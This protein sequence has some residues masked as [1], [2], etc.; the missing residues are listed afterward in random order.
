MINKDAEKET[1]EALENKR[2]GTE[3]EQM[4]NLPEESERGA[5]KKKKEKET[6][7]GAKSQTSKATASKPPAG[8]SLGSSASSSGTSNKNK[9]TLSNSQNSASTSSSPA[10]AALAAFRQNL[11]LSERQQMKLALQSSKL[12]HHGV[13]MQQ[14]AV[15]LTTG[16]TE[17][18]GIKRQQPKGRSA[19]SNRGG[20]GG[21]GGGP[22]G[23]RAGVPSGQGRG[24]GEDKKIEKGSQREKKKGPPGAR[25]DAPVV[26]S[27]SSGAGPKG[28]KEKGK[29]KEAARGKGGKSKGEDANSRGACGSRDASRGPKGGPGKEDETEEPKEKE[30]TI[31]ELDLVLDLKTRGK[32]N[33]HISRLAWNRFRVAER[34]EEEVEERWEILSGAPW[35]SEGKPQPQSKAKGRGKKVP[36]SVQR[37]FEVARGFIL[38]RAPEIRCLGLQETESQP[39]KGEEG[40]QAD[41][42][43]ISISS[44]SPSASASASAGVTSSSTS[45]SAS[46]HKAMN[47]KLKELGRPS[48]EQVAT[49]LSNLDKMKLEDPATG[50]VEGLRGV[51]I[52]LEEAPGEPPRPRLS[53][54][55][56][57]QLERARAGMLP[58]VDPEPPRR[59]PHP[60]TPKKGRAPPKKKRFRCRG[61]FKRPRCRLEEGTRGTKAEIW[62]VSSVSSDDSF[63]LPELA[64]GDTKLFLDVPRNAVPDRLIF[65]VAFSFG[66]KPDHPP[67]LFTRWVPLM[68]VRPW[69]TLRPD[70]E[71][72]NWR[73]I[74]NYREKFDANQP[75][76]FAP[77]S[78]PTVPP[79]RPLL[80]DSLLGEVNQLQV[81]GRFP[82]RPPKTTTDCPLVD[83]RHP[84]GAPDPNGFWHWDADSDASQFLAGRAAF[85]DRSQL[86]RESNTGKAMYSLAS[87]KV[88]REIEESQGVER[89]ADRDA[90]ML[91]T[92]RLPEQ[93]S[94]PPPRRFRRPPK[95]PFEPSCDPAGCPEGQGETDK[96]SVIEISEEE[97]EDEEETKKGG[98]NEED[99]EK[100][101]K[102]KKKEKHRK[103]ETDEGKRQRSPVT[104]GILPEKKKRRT[105]NEGESEESETEKEQRGK[106]GRHSLRDS[107]RQETDQE[108]DWEARQKKKTHSEKKASKYRK[109]DRGLEGRDDRHT[110]FH[111]VRKER[112]SHHHEKDKRKE[113]KKKHKK[114]EER[115]RSSSPLSREKVRKEDE[116]R[117]RETT[118]FP[119]SPPPQPPIPI[120]EL[121]YVPYVMP[122]ARQPVLPSSALTLPS[123]AAAAAA[124]VP[125][126]A[127]DIGESSPEN[128]LPSLP[129]FEKASDA[130]PPPPPLLPADDLPR[131]VEGVSSSSSSSSAAPAAAAD[132]AA[133]A[134]KVPLT[135]ADESDK[136]VEEEKEEGESEE[137]DVEEDPQGWDP[138]PDE[139]LPEELRERRRTALARAAESGDWEDID[140]S[141]ENEFH[142]RSVKDSKAGVKCLFLEFEAAT[143]LAGRQMLKKLHES[144]VHLKTWRLSEEKDV[145]AAI[146]AAMQKEEGDEASAPSPFSSPQKEPVAPSSR[147]QS[148]DCKWQPAEASVI[149]PSYIAQTEVD[150]NGGEEAEFIDFTKDEQYVKC[151]ADEENEDLFAVADTDGGEIKLHLNI[152]AEELEAAL[153]RNGLDLGGVILNNRLTEVLIE[154]HT[155]GE[156]AEETNRRQGES[157]SAE[158]GRIL[159]S[160]AAVQ[161]T[162]NGE[163]KSRLTEAVP[164]REAVR[165]F[166]KAMKSHANRF[167]LSTFLSSASSSSS[168]G[169]L[170]SY[171]KE[172]PIDE[173]QRLPILKVAISKIAGIGVYTSEKI[174]QGAIVCEYAGQVIEREREDSR[175]AMYT[176][177]G[178][179]YSTYFFELSPDLIID[180]TLRASVARFINCSCEPNC[181]TTKVQ[182]K[183]GRLQKVVLTAMRDIEAGEE[184]SYDYK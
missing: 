43:P 134:A 7:D 129:L 37:F 53:R 69:M 30:W 161:Q 165:R 168:V 63:D 149:P 154:D 126:K 133:R 34:S 115:E 54:T 151:L 55:Y 144:K 97:G 147:H 22:P 20:Q 58:A 91:A 8:P 75:C 103:D 48:V 140:W 62:D 108:S 9:Q 109:S 49:A 24:G 89:D 107:Y 106:E 167:S 125:P 137:E 26:P 123:A 61:R 4:K 25:A 33:V 179:P 176:A 88:Q 148:T 10:S 19:G 11:H 83:V 170:D 102:K 177:H 80:K 124:A 157:G 138:D 152:S 81:R 32:A 67:P 31:H 111:K 16:G 13:Q 50:T 110:D 3:K 141:L 42:S 99:E 112:E 40:S 119:P 66:A 57:Q 96:Y 5:E 95:G 160:T 122:S 158:S 70:P 85:S 17:A 94:I 131:A 73:F 18:G 41:D 159:P 169:L 6:G 39:S 128:S 21:G 142:A 71:E 45:V 139:N 14:G 27:A 29:E 77:P 135:A 46:S 105:E 120:S 153:V 163:K 82:L 178:L 166:R 104:A 150:E 56:D 164:F 59:H 145:M 84:K 65:R 72:F 36:E 92:S 38:E 171:D 172:E 74:E 121:P 116:Q 2:D 146:R 35:D 114:G 12:A 130:S 113:K 52:M 132:P 156:D 117:G 174:K 127:V 47:E 98:E 175:E 101:K 180:A 181:K 1:E 182:W 79:T 51:K 68:W 183:S 162:G 155:G 118:L 86:F 136:D 44:A 87:W 90:A 173:T 78:L 184:L 100:K 64:E 93:R 15:S 60:P 76:W 28:T 143:E 23:K